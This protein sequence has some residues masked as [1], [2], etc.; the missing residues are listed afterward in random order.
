MSEAGLEKAQERARALRK[1]IEEHNYRY[2]VLDQ[3]LIN[4][5]EFDRLMRELQEL[6]QK[7]PQLWDPDSP[8]NRVGGEPLE[9]FEP[10]E[11]KVP[12][13][14]LDNA[15]NREELFE[16]DARVRRLS[17]LETVDYLCELKFD[18]LAVSLQYE[19]GSF[20]RGA[21]RGDGYT[22]EDITQNLRT[23]RQIPLQLPEPLTM[24]VRGEAYINREAFRQL[25]RQREEQG[26]MLFANPRNAAAGSLRQLDPRLAAARPLRIF[27]Y[28]LGEHNLA[29][30]TQEEV[31]VYLEKMR[32]PVNQN[33]TVCRGPEEVW[34]YCRR[35][36]DKREELPYETDGIVIKVNS[37]KWQKEL[38]ATARSPRWAIAYKYP[39]EEKTTR[40]QDIQVNVGR[41]GAITPVA[42]LEPVHLSG[43]VVQRAS[44]HNEDFVK[45][46]EVKIGDTVTIHKAGEIIPEVLRVLKDKRTGEEKEFTMP[47]SCPSCGSETTRLSGEAALRCLNPKCP[48]QLV[49][50]LVHFA[51]RRAMD[52][53][54]LGPAIAEMLYR[55]DLAGDVGDL[56]YLKEEQLTGLERMAEK[57]AANLVG[58]IENSK[59]KPLRR[60]LFG[61]GISFVG[62]KAARLL[63]EKFKDLERLQKAK[64][65]ELT[66]IP[67]IGPKIAQAVS[68]FF[69]TPETQ[70]VIDK[71]K[72]AG[73]NF[74]EPAAED[75]TQAAGP[76]LSGKT[77]VFSGAL[78]G[79]TRERATALVEEQGGKVSSSV[80]KN[81]DYLVAGDEPGSKLEKA[82]SLEVEVLDQSRF[83][84]LLGLQ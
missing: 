1:E 16:F 53:E 82:R 45:E 27:F 4:D 56:Y 32:L 62:E 70:P 54:G 33:Y 80:S 7:Y 34:Q 39:P 22:G 55:E 2:H 24:E 66:E 83:E 8:T 15:F 81:T 65:E 21:T 36:Q 5:H 60:L 14:G 50:K 3:P 42:I 77:F 43:S 72:R 9:A 11:H 44:L 47:R 6:E 74:K 58:A 35:W 73:V 41:T 63:A 79:Y 46:K 18:G 25:N 64:E 38:G 78:E 71:L 68:G 17:G 49:E 26:L 12:M 51:S 30:E 40:V 10:L 23:I 76:D 59:G 29:L 52:I 48:A 31:L 57:S 13:L 37:L 19:N 28:G 61:L 84:E 69:R 20:V 67:E 75:S